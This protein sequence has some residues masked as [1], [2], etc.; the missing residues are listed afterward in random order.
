VG[1]G[2]RTYRAG[3]RE[4]LDGYR[5]DEMCPTGRGQVLLP[6]PNRLEDGSYEFEGRH[7]QLPLN[8]PES[9]N[10]LHGLVRWSAWTLGE[11]EP[12]RVVMEHQLHPQ[13]GYP[14]SLAVSIE[15]ALSDTGLTITTTATNA[16]PDACPYGCGAHP[17]LTLGT[18]T[19]DSAILTAPGRQVLRADSRGIP[20]D[21]AAVAGTDYDF[22]RPRAVG[23]TQ[24]DHCFTDLERNEGL[25]RVELRAPDGTAGLTLWMDESY[26]YLML[27]TGDPFP[28]VNRRSLAVEPMTCPPNAFSTGE[29][30]IRLE[31]GSSFTSTW[32]IIPLG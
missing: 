14:F 29:A 17:Y 4:L 6:W 8:E 7:H 26:G 21:Q 11:R 9:R 18:E 23:S 19:V 22:T 2:L 3:D 28:D 20:T 5:P 25:A 24:L 16:G 27:F 13:P 12:D 15:Y 1:G 31:P 10:A 32:G 30:L